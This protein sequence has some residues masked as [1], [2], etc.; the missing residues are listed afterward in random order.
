MRISLRH[1]QEYE[2]AP[3]GVRI[4][5]L[6]ETT[7]TYLGNGTEGDPH[8]LVAQWFTKDG[9]LVAEHDPCAVRATKS[10]PDEGPRRMAP[11]EWAKLPSWFPHV[12]E[13][14]H[15]AAR[16]AQ[17]AMASPDGT[18]THRAVVNAVVSL[19]AARMPA[20]KSIEVNSIGR[21]MASVSHGVGTVEW[22][23]Y[24]AAELALQGFA[25]HGGGS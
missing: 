25:A 5:E 15:T 13:L 23:K 10:K 7:L 11:A 14:D 16:A 1:G 4:V 17:R 19:I 3:N 6:V 12:N 20:S 22:N 2:A 18:P 9:V 24:L 21:A 8:R